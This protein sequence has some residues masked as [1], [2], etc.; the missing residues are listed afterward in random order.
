MSNNTVKRLNEDGWFNH[1]GRGKVR[2]ASSVGRGIA[3]EIGT[4]KKV[5]DIGCGAGAC[6]LP[7]RDAGN[8]VFG[9]DVSPSALAL[10]RQKGLD[11]ME[12]DIE[13]EPVDLLAAKGPFDAVVF[14]DVLEHLIDP[15][16]VLKDKILPIL[17]PGGIVVATVPNFVFLRYRLELLLG[18]VSHFNNDDATG[19]DLPR[20]YNLGHK[21]LF[22]RANLRET[23]RLAGFSKIRVEPE[24]FAESLSPFWS[25]PV[26]RN[27]RD[28]IKKLWPTL[29]AARFLVVAEKPR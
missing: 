19:Y 8:E 28:D 5:L 25:K 17:K 10:C 21:T 29:L 3:R 18:R 4:G 2:G 12:Y 20:P 6:L 26:W 23:F 27:L 13:N 22:N 16:A 9:V 1:I 11:V 15:L 7:L 14:A 24:L